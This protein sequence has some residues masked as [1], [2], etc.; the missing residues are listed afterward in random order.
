MEQHARLEADMCLDV[1]QTPPEM[2][3]GCCLAGCSPVQVH[4]QLRW[5]PAVTLSVSHNP[6]PY[7]KPLY[8]RLQTAP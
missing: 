2:H 3:A 5:L 7:P 1:G 8:E 4:A 6:N